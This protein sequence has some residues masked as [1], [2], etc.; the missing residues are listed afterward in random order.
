MKLSQD[1]RSPDR[2]L[3]PEPSEYEAGVLIRPRRLVLV[4]RSIIISELNAQGRE[5]AEYTRHA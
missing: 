1:S 5:Y 3:N 4:I 2:D